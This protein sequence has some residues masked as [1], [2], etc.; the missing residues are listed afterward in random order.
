[1]VSNKNIWARSM[2]SPKLI[3]FKAIVSNYLVSRMNTGSSSSAVKL[4][5]WQRNTANQ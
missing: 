4:K 3:V 5:Y 1:M 2:C